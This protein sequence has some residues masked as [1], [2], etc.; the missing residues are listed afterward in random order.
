MTVWTV[1]SQV[2]LSMEFFRQEYWSVS[3]LPSPGDP[4]HPGIESRSPVLRQILY[5]LSH[6]GSLRAQR[7]T[8]P[9][10]IHQHSLVRPFI[11]VCFRES[12][13]TLGLL[14]VK[15]A[16]FVGIRV[17]LCTRSSVH[18]GPAWCVFQEHHLHLKVKQ[19]GLERGGL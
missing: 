1:A 7:K 5:H 11:L 15:S 9:R 18:S 14:T 8:T 6:Q 13:C 17:E 10:H 12:A 4:P 16:C 19:D 2:P 3:P